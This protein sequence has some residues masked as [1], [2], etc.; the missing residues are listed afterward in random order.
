MLS[1]HDFCPGSFHLQLQVRAPYVDLPWVRFTFFSTIRPH[2]RPGRC[3]RHDH[4][5]G[6]LPHDTD[7]ADACSAPCTHAR[8]LKIDL[9]TVAS[10][11]T[12]IV[13]KSCSCDNVGAA[14]VLNA[15]LLRSASCPAFELHDSLSS[16]CLSCWCSK[17]AL[18]VFTSGC[19]SLDTPRICRTSP[20]SWRPCPRSV[21]NGSQPVCYGGR[22]YRMT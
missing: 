16:Q 13:A 2:R 22:I 4:N 15:A 1:F 19:D 8:L 12:R 14:A 17:E 18:S 20:L 9:D 10:M 21:T 5:E 3:T 11:Y 6:L 7:D